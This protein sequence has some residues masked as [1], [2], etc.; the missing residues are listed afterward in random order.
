MNKEKLVFLAKDLRNEYPC[1]PRVMLGGFVILA[2]CLE[3]CRSFLVG[4][5]GEYNYWPCTLCAELEAFTGIDHEEFKNFVATGASDKEI[6]E[7][8]NTKSKEKEKIE[9]IRWNN[10]MR[11]MRPS[12]MSD[13]A[14]E[15]LES[16]ISENVP[17]HRPVYVWFD[18]F[19]LEEK[20]L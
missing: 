3:K 4:L 9:I 15:F 1:S 2:R 5:N 12:E 14:Q 8:V 17:K 20:R 13:Q 11:D 19:D 7:W 6:A 10:K 16:Y 18:V